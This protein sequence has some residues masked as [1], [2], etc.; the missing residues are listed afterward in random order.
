MASLHLLILHK[1]MIEETKY[2]KTGNQKTSQSHWGLSRSREYVW[3]E[4]GSCS[5]AGNKQAGANIPL[6]WTSDA[7]GR[8]LEGEPDRAILPSNLGMETARGFAWRQ[9]R[10]SVWSVGETS[11]SYP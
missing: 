10:I 8:I 9:S 2:R 6:G 1:T 3:S 11:F 4:G 7:D 5:E